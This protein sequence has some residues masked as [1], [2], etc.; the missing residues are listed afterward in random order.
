M[1]VSVYQTQHVA[2]TSRIEKAIDYKIT[3]LSFLV[4]SMKQKWHS[5]TAVTIRGRNAVMVIAIERSI[6]Q[7]IM[8]RSRW[9]SIKISLKERE[10]SG[11]TSEIV[12]AVSLADVQT[13]IIIIEPQDFNLIA[14]SLLRERADA[15][16]IRESDSRPIRRDDDGYRIGSCRN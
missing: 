6:R 11:E 2:S 12:V 5:V 3:G 16:S 10:I 14:V 15:L 7:Q 4:G 8:P 13:C 1:P 9:Y